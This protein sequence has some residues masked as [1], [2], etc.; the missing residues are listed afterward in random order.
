MYVD[1][2]S[3]DDAKQLLAQTEDN[4]NTKEC[5]Q[6]DRTVRRRAIALVQEGEGGYA[7]SMRL[8]D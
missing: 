4:Y 6:A 3:D 5:C 2:Q 1:E 8:C 7:K